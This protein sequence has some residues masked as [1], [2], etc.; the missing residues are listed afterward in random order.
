MRSGDRVEPRRQ[1]YAEG[2]WREAT[3]YYTH[4]RDELERLGDVTQAA[5]AGANLGEVLISRGL[6]EEAETVLDGRAD[7]SPRSRARHG[8]HLRGDAART[9]RTGP[10][11]LRCSHRG[12]RPH[13]RRGGRDRQRVVCPRSVD[14]P[15]RGATPDEAN[16]RARSTCSTTPSARSGSSRHRSRRTSRAS[17]RS[18][19]ARSATPRRRSSRPSWR[20]RSRAASDC[21]TRRS[22]RLGPSRI[23][24]RVEGEARAR[25]ALDEAESLAQRLAEMS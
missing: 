5:F 10:R 1:A 8:F 18:R 13:R 12:P 6:L 16:R 3:T 4:S 9:S 23:C 2:R 21:S 24:S 22:R 14:L 20:S 7:D 25:E 15:R 19:W 17:V 11:R